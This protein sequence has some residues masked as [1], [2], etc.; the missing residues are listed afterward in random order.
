MAKMII[1]T[2]L[3]MMVRPNSA[4]SQ[5]PDTVFLSWIKSVSLS[6][7]SIKHDSLRLHQLFANKNLVCIGE[8]THGSSELFTVRQ[9]L[10]QYLIEHEGFTCIAIEAPLT[11][12][13]AINRYVLGYGSDSDLT[14]KSM[15][16]WLY[17]TEEIKTFIQWL[18]R[19]NQG[20][21]SKVQ[22]FGMDMS[23]PLSAAATVRSFVAEQKPG[24]VK[25]VDSAY[26]WCPV[27]NK[28]DKE[29]ITPFIT[30]S[31]MPMPILQRRRQEA[32]RIYGIVRTICT[33]KNRY[34]TTES[35]WALRNAEVMEM[36]LSDMIQS[37]L[38]KR[39][40]RK[41]QLRDSLM[42]ENIRWILQRSGYQNQSDSGAKNRVIVFAHNGHIS[43]GL[44]EEGDSTM[45]AHCKR[46]FGEEMVSIA[47]GFYEGAFQAI[48]EASE[49]KR[50]S[51]KPKVFQALKTYP[52]SLEWYCHQ[53]KMQPPVLLPF[54]SLNTTIRQWLSKPHWLHDVGATMDV[55]P[56]KEMQFS[57]IIP[58]QSFDAFLYVD[59]VSASRLL[60]Q[61]QRK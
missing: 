56:T 11:E 27:E 61:T 31:N 51:G 45:G 7:P 14:M 30:L 44:D 46:W 6:L 16:Y 15:G 9:T 36:C 18:R 57:S 50:S 22:F 21:S 34:N 59:R 8:A 25:E 54:S 1:I 43:Y 41:T 28:T 33:E 24:A 5:K 26:S 58:L 40:G 60:E 29:R 2:I 38:P 35:Q 4:I 10:A 32:R 39:K 52:S 37:R 55:P 12:V 47:T 23:V 13:G 17:I 20:R 48:P 19:Y 53:A 3:L 49:A 42:A